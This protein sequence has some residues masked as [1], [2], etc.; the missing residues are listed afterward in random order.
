MNKE[1]HPDEIE[2]QHALPTFVIGLSHLERLV[3]R[4]QE[5]EPCVVATL[6]PTQQRFL[7]PHVRETSKDGI[8]DE[9]SAL[10]NPP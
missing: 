3:G 2:I 6:S 9:H 4:L 1:Y 8:C 7:V 10:C 5:V